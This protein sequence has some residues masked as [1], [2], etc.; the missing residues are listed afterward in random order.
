MS[1]PLSDRLLAD[2]PAKVLSL[3]GAVALFFFYQL[4]RLE[5]RPLSV[6]LVVVSNEN[7]VP[8]SQYPRTVRLVLRGESNAIYAVLED[9]LEATLD[10]RG[11]TS[12]G[13]WRVPVRVEKKGS[14]LG[15]DPL[16]ISVN[17][18]DVAISIEL[19]VVKEIQVVPSFRGYLEPGYELAGFKLVPSRIEAAGPASIMEKL[20]DAATEPVELT[21]R[22]DNFSIRTKIAARDPLVRFMSSDIIEFSAEVK[23]AL[24]YRT[25]QDLEVSYVGLRDDLVAKTP[26]PAGSARVAA[27]SKEL[28][29]FVP[30]AGVLEADLSA[31]TEPGV[32]AVAVVPRFPAGFDVETWLPMVATIS[33]ERVAPGSRTQVL[34]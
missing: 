13:V 28:E 34:P 32:Y 5:E 25:Y 33:V 10:L 21:G 20:E 2:W 3:A 1:R 14:A 7:F 18:S 31:I 26:A 9:D 8:A 27:S 6:P 4:N 22:S 15:I 23:K 11:Y 12:A 19:R 16:E 29:N 24:V 30:S 17:P